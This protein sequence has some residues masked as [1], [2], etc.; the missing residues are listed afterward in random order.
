MLNAFSSCLDRN[1]FFVFLFFSYFK[2]KI[3]IKKKK[4]PKSL[5]FQFLGVLI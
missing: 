3:K 2:L 5:N 4:T 1:K